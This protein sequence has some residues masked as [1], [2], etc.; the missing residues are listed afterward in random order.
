MIGVKVRTTQQGVPRQRSVGVFRSSWQKDV[1]VVAG[2]ALSLVLVSAR[3]I[4]DEY[5]LSARAQ[6]TEATVISKT[7]GHGW[8]EYEYFFNGRRYEGRTP[9]DATGRPFDKVG[10]GD[11]LVVNFDPLH[12]GVSGTAGTREALTSTAPF[13]VLLLIGASAVVFV[14]QYG[15][16]NDL[17]PNDALQRTRARLAPLSADVRRQ[18]QASHDH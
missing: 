16:S 5:F 18:E 4:R 6:P 11:K 10:R 15:A 7:S 17:L 3:Q 9:A 13:L 12:P 1:L 2:I 14:R 8:I